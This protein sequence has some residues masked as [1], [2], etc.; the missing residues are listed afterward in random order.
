MVLRWTKWVFRAGARICI[1]YKLKVKGMAFHAVYMLWK[2]LF[3]QS[4]GHDNGYLQCIKQTRA[5]FTAPVGQAVKIG[6]SCQGIT[7]M[8]AL[9][10]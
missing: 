7:L 10:G 8:A 5:Y 2:L 9:A 4:I 6:C 1:F 3:I